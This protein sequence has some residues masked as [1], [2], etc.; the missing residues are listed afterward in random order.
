MENMRQNQT[1]PS[2]IDEMEVYNYSGQTKEIEEDRF[3]LLVITYAMYKIGKLLSF[4]SFLHFVYC[5]LCCLLTGF[6]WI[7]LS[8]Y[9]SPGEGINKVYLPFLVPVGVFG[10]ILSFLVRNKHHSFY[11][12]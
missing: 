12:K 10:N 1:I 3:F 6:N 8:L 4:S 7:Y 5:N 2:H 9:F 11:F